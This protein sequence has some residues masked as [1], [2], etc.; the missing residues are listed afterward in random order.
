MPV[1]LNVLVVVSQ[2]AICHKVDMVGVIEAIMVEVV[3]G[4]SCDR[5]DQ[6]KVVKLSDLLQITLFDKEIHHLG[7]ISSMQVIMIGYVLS[8]SSTYRVQKCN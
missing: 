2:G 1:L 8:V 5:R 6:V 7:N 3:A 4:G